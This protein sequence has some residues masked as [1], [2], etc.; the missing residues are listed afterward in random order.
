[1]N[2]SY[3]QGQIL[4]VIR[5]K[6]VFTQDELARELKAQGVPA[7]QVTL[8]RDIREL[9]LVKTTEG[10]QQLSTEPA[11]PQLAVVAAEVLLDARAAQNLVVLHT[12]SGHASSLAAAL[13]REE[14]PEIVG[15]IAGDNTVL[16]VTSDSATAEETRRKLLG[17]LSER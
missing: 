15:T 2:K 1:M 8:S 10:Y 13:D 14:W 16:V 3:R 6:Q 17:Y 7:T 4:K 11:G 5:A 12:L 9:G